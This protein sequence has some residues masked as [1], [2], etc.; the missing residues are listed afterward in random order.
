MKTDC[1]VFLLFALIPVKEIQ[2]FHNYE[3]I[4]LEFL[5]AKFL[6]VIFRDFSRLIFRGSLLGVFISE[7]VLVPL[8]TIDFFQPGTDNERER[9]ETL[10]SVLRD[11]G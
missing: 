11:Y 9:S 3:K 6:N 5:N 4:I 10:Q 7:N 1:T 8:V 2:R